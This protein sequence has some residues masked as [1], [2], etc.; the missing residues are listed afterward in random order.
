MQNN[1]LGDLMSWNEINNYQ[2]CFSSLFGKPFKNDNHKGL[3]EVNK[4]F[5][6]IRVACTDFGLWQY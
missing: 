3:E 4:T 2:R 5:G 1:Y 6:S